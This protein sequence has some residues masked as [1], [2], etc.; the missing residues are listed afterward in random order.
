VLSRN[1]ITCKG[2]IALAAAL[3]KGTVE[4]KHRK[5]KARENA[6]SVLKGEAPRASGNHPRT[7]TLVELV[8]DHNS[9]GDEGGKALAQVL[10]VRPVMTW[11]I[12]D[13]CTR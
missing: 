11:P 5:D 10:Q 6:K 8:L 2:A 12:C 9:I 1:D 3:S 7:H 4:A 13:V